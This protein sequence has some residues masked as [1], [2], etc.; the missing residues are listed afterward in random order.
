M[1]V[2][3]LPGLITRRS[4]KASI[5]NKVDEELRFHIDMQATDYTRLGI[6]PE[7]SRVMAEARFGDVERIKSECIRISTGNT[8]LTWML[9]FVFLMSLIAGLIIRAL[10]PEMNVTRV[11]T[12]MM[13]I[14]GLG[15]LLVYAKR[16]G[17]M[18]FT[19]SSS[20]RLGLNNSPPVSFDE[21]GR[22][23]FERVKSL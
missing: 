23:P 17:A 10:S 19:R 1:A 4:R 21:Q 22:T 16:A 9:T 13:M 2:K 12:V 15:I 7:E 6:T 3:N 14:G 11:G 5:E 18:V 8:F 20:V